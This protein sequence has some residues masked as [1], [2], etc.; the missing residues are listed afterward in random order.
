[1][2][3]KKHKIYKKIKSI[4]NVTYYIQTLEKIANE[5]SR[6]LWLNG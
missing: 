5:R 2:N 3:F 1:M 6:L 4:L